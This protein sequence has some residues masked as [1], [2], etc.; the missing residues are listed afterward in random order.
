MQRAR[1]EMGIEVARFSGSLAALSATH[2]RREA[3]IRG[4]NQSAYRGI[5]FAKSVHWIGGYRRI[6]RLKSIHW[7]D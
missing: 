3:P 1:V 7:I 2:V 5:H 4:Q 6:L